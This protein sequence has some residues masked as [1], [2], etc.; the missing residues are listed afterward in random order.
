MSNELDKHISEQLHRYES[1]VDAEAIWAAVRPPRRRRP[2]FWLLLVFGLVSLSGGAWWFIS[3]GENSQL[4]SSDSP[5]SSTSVISDNREESVTSTSTVLE[6]DANSATESEAPNAQIESRLDDTDATVERVVGDSQRVALDDSEEMEAASETSTFGQGNFVDGSTTAQ[7]SEASSNEQ[8]E[9]L[10]GL[11]DLGNIDYEQQ[12]ISPLAVEELSQTE[13]FTEQSS[14]T[15]ETLNT[16]DVNRSRLVESIDYRLAS[17]GGLLAERQNTLDQEITLPEYRRNR[18]KL[19]PWSVQLDAAYMLIDRDLQVEG[20]SLP[21]TW[22]E[23]RRATESLLEAWSTDLSVGYA[24]HKNWQ[25]RAGL[26][27]TQINTQFDYLTTSSRTDTV[28]GVQTIIFNPD[29][30][31]DSITGPILMYET[32]QRERQIFNSFRQW[33]LPILLAYENGFGSLSFI[34]EAGARI[35]L[36]RSWEGQVLGQD[37]REVVSLEDQEWYRTELGLSLQAGIQLGYE[38]TPQLQLRAG[39]TMRYTPAAFSKPDQGFKEGY[40]LFGLQVGVRYQLR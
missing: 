25:V 14:V 40:Q 6:P 11:T 12:D 36:S 37:L 26:G 34:A 20:D 3:T 2:W 10:P 5:S 21:T 4:A 15:E 18:R 33:E 32:V 7:G 1:A 13:A 27:Y 17:R 35:R 23:Q 19:S 38:L 22:V 28:D 29:N 39:G 30:T 9:E 31:V 16:S 8:F 24:F